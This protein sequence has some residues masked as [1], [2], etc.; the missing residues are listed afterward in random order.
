MSR[1]I[2]RKRACPEQ[3]RRGGQP[4]NQNARKHGLYSSRLSAEQVCELA[5]ILNQGDEDPALIALR[6]KLFSALKSAPDNRRVLMEA[7]KILSKWY[8]SNYNLGKK[9]GASFKAFIRAAFKK[10]I[11]N[12]PVLT[13]RI[14]AGPAETIDN[15]TERIEAESLKKTPCL[16]VK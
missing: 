8:L 14:V 16:A 10:M 15:L 12:Q 6:I 5:N 7:S 13:E 2:K 11:Q 3:R 4:G 1:K 9:D